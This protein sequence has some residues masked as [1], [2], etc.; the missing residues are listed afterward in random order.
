MFP[1]L[2]LLTILEDCIKYA[3]VIDQPRNSIYEFSRFKITVRQEYVFKKVIA[4]LHILHQGE[5]NEVM[6]RGK[7]LA[8]TTRTSEVICDAQLCQKRAYKK[9]LSE[10]LQLFLLNKT[11]VLLVYTR[12]IAATSLKSAAMV[13]QYVLKQN[14]LSLYETRKWC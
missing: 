14:T 5:Q 12:Q 9:L 4:L 3:L 10:A 13:P 6:K 1:F 7:L 11:D 2:I 8:V